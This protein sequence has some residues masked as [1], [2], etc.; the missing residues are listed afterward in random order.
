MAAY[1]DPFLD[2]PAGDFFKPMLDDAAR[3]ARAALPALRGVGRVAAGVG[4]F[5]GPIGLVAGLALT[6]WEMRHWALLIQGMLPV[7]GWRFCCAFPFTPRATHIRSGWDY[8]GGSGCAP[9]ATC[10]AAQADG[11]PFQAY[12]GV[13]NRKRFYHQYQVVPGVLRY[14]IVLT[15]HRVAA[16]G[17]PVV[18]GVRV[19]PTWFLPASL[20]PKAAA[21]ATDVA[22]P[23]PRPMP[24]AAIPAVRALPG[25][26]QTREGAYDVEPKPLAPPIV[27]TIGDDAD[28]D[29][30]VRPRPA[31]RPEVINRPHPAEQKVRLDAKTRNAFRLMALY[32]EANDFIDVFWRALPAAVRRR[33][34]NTSY[35]RML[36]VVQ[37]MDQINWAAL[38]ALIALNELGDTTNASRLGVARD[39]SNR[40]DPTG[41]LWRA[42]Q[43]FG[44]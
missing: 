19:P 24:W 39:I 15:H 29:T 31:E 40:I 44:Y 34:R 1:L 11:S 3:A 7:G 22:A 37:N 27:I 38:P 36:A 42:W 18:P 14:D 16:S 41:T 21:A 43:S 25:S 28:G 4:R 9:A 2:L 8:V 26:A 12:T 10:L 23:F 13:E 35:G 6:A 33:Y 30:V 17:A 20:I 32:S 5:A